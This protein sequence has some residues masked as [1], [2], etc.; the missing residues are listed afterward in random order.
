MVSESALI[1]AAECEMI[2]RFYAEHYLKTGVLIERG[3]E[4]INYFQGIRKA[5]QAIERMKRDEEYY[6]V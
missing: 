6:G 4:R 2:I 1:T 5:I 3:L